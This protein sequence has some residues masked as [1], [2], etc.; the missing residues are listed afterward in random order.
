MTMASAIMA[1]INKMMAMISSNHSSRLQPDEG[2]DGRAGVSGE[3]PVLGVAVAVACGTMSG[4][5]V[6]VA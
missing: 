1:A 3:G 6:A 5:G 2:P 4:V